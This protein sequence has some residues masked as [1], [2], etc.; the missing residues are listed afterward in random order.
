MSPSPSTYAKVCPESKRRYAIPR[1]I[2]SPFLGMSSPR[3]G[4]FIPRISGVRE[5]NEATEPIMIWET[6]YR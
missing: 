5:A 1:Y 3:Y 6:G 2:K 4:F